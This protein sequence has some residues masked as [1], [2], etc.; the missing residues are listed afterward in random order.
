MRT[1]APNSAFRSLSRSLQP[2]PL[3]SQPLVAPDEVKDP[4][5]EIFHFLW[6][7][8]ERPGME[9][10]DFVS[11]FSWLLS[12]GRTAHR[13]LPPAPPPLPPVCTKKTTIHSSRAHAACLPC[14]SCSANPPP[15]LLSAKLLAYQID[16]RGTPT[17]QPPK[18]C[19][20]SWCWRVDGVPG[21]VWLTGTRVYRVPDSGFRVQC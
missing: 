14:S 9:E 15:Q 3:P 10:V 8:R 5:R 13:V 17:Y 18:A 6:L 19:Q 7:S 4:L 2:P 21:G 1:L 11:T 12:Y 16:R 20:T